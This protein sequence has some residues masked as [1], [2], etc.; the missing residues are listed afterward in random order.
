[1]TAA[2]RGHAQIVTLLLEAGSDATR[3]DRSGKTA[4][5]LSTSDAVRQAL[6]S[7]YKP[8]ST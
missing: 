8:R 5:D 2:Q 3:R 1:M 7:I 6:L 4:Y